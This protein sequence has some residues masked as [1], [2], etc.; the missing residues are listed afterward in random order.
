LRSIPSI[1]L[2]DSTDLPS[3]INTL[4]LQIRMDAVGLLI[5]ASCFSYASYTLYSWQER[6]GRLRKSIQF[7]R[8][9]TPLSASIL[10]KALESNTSSYILNNIMGFEEGRNYSKGLAIVQGIVDSEQV[11]RSVLNHSSK[12]VLSSVSSELIFS[13]NRNLEE[14]DGRTDIKFVSELNLTD[15]TVDSDKV[16][17]SSNGTV[18]YTDALHMIHS[19]VHMRSLSPF[20]KFLSWVLFCIKL[21]LS[22]SN[23][24]KRLSG[25]KVGTKRV[26]R[27]IM[28]GQFM[29]AFGEVIYDKYT[30]ELRMPNPLYFLKDKEQLIHKLREKRISTSKNSTLLFTLALFLGFLVV[31]R[32]FKIVRALFAKYSKFRDLEHPDIFYRLKKIYT[33]SFNCDVCAENVRNVIFKPCLHLSICTVCDDKLQVKHCPTCKQLVNDRIRIFVV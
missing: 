3:K 26:E 6:Q 18:K 5:E 30:K 22:M 29:V 12:L 17:L 13:N 25:F 2:N 19:I 20:E 31:K 33:S 15:P 10:Q 24:G 8:H 16:I 21:F 23:V 11:I 7:L 4:H 28:I 32:S 14:A 1:R 27:G 9:A